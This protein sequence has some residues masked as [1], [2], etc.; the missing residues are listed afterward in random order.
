M[1]IAEDAAKAVKLATEFEATVHTPAMVL[2]LFCH[3]FLTLSKL[4]FYRVH[5]LYN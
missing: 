1:E 5:S 3:R 2:W 4:I